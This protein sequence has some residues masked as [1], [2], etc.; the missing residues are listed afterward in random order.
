MLIVQDCEKASKNAG[1]LHVRDKVNIRRV[2]CHNYKEASDAS[3]KGQS[4]CTENR[5]R[6]SVEVGHMPAA[7]RPSDESMVAPDP[8]ELV[9]GCGPVHR[10]RRAGHWS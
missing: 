1:T 8:T 5:S 6:P 4:P 9:I 2:P 3:A 10:G 7:G